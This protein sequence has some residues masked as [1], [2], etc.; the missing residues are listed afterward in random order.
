MIELFERER[1]DRSKCKTVTTN[2]AAA[3]QGSQQGVIKGIQRFSPNCVGFLLYSSPR[4]ISYE[5][6]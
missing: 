2:G 5:K 4:N 3:I 1:L 6:P